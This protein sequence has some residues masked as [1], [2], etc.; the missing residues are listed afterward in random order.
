[1]IGV[2]TCRYSTRVSNVFPSSSG[3]S[4]LLEIFPFLFEGRRDEI[5]FFLL[6]VFRRRHRLGFIDAITRRLR[7][8]RFGFSVG[9]RVP[10]LVTHQIL[11]PHSR[12]AR[13]S[14]VGR[15]AV[16]A[17]G[18]SRCKLHWRYRGA[19]HSP[20]LVRLEPS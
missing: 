14:V 9:G 15:R 6:V 19:V 12:V 16:A 10:S 17:T 13:C 7:W 18:E 3:R 4:K 8:A 1:M 11:A 5:L 20:S 2:L